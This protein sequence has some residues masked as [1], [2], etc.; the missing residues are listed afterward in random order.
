MNARERY[1]IAGRL[2]GLSEKEKIEVIVSYAHDSKSA[3]AVAS[4]LSK[5]YPTVYKLLYA[6]TEDVTSIAQ[7]DGKTAELLNVMR[8]TMSDALRVSVLSEPTPITC[9]TDVLEYLRFTLGGINIEKFLV[10]SLDN[11]NCPV[12]IDEITAGTVNR[13]V[14]FPRLVFEVALKNGATS[15]ILVH[16]HPGGTAAPS[17]EDWNTTERVHK[18]GRLIDIP[19]HDHIIIASPTNTVSMRDFKRWPA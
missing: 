6:K 8:D 2:D 15:V 5:K 1:R 10:V 13:C 4:Q 14:I 7:D 11:R 12:G 3:T 16:N 18:A 17:D 9:R 19:I